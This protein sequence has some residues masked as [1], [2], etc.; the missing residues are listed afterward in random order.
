M[1]FLIVSRPKERAQMVCIGIVT[2]ILLG[3]MTS[4]REKNKQRQPIFHTYQASLGP[5]IM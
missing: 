3:L 4:V 2:A 5:C 1:I